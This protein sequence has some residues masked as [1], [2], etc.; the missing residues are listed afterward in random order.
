MRL[1]CV[2][3]CGIDAY[4]TTGDRLPGGI[5]FNFA[6]RARRAFPASDEIRIISALGADPAA[7][8]IRNALKVS[9]V[10]YDFTT[11]DGATPVQRIALEASGERRFV[12]YD[13]GVL[14]RFRPSAAQLAAIEEADWLI[15]PHFVQI[16]GLF[17][18]LLQA[19]RRGALAVDFADFRAHPDFAL[20]ERSLEQVDVA[21][22]GLQ[23]E[24]AVTLGRIEQLA[25]DRN[26]LLVVTLA[27]AGS[28]AYAGLQ[29]YDQEAVRVPVV[30]DTT[31]AG[32]AFAAGFLSRYCHDT[33]VPACLEAGARLA[34]SAIQQVGGARA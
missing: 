13:A 12:G 30:V 31:G 6:V 25:R 9:G 7:I 14:E 18:F 17:D 29:R 5:T 4:E 24:D 3:D 22:F 8:V 19:P 1:V 10:G 16:A 32:D 23:P 20:L 11:L 2:G 21:F 15:V 26:C 33:A 28:R 27:A 34:A